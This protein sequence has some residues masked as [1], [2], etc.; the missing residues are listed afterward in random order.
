MQGGFVGG[1]VDDLGSQVSGRPLEWLRELW[2]VRGECQNLADERAEVV[3]EVGA[4]DR[5]ETVA[6]LLKRGF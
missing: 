3:A 4:M 5:D 6:E 2:S 1:S